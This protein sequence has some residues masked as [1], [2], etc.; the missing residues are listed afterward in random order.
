MRTTDRRDFLKASAAA[1][2]APAILHRRAA[3]AQAPI[4]FSTL[5]CPTWDWTTILDRAAEWGFAAVELRG[6]QGQMDLTRCPEFAPARLAR[7]RR[8][9][10]ERNLLISD[11]GASCRL[12]EKDPKVRA[13]QLD[14]ARRFIELAHDLGAPYVRVFGDKWIAGES[15]EITLERIG[16]GLR[17]LGRFAQSGKVGVIIET[18][19]DFT[20]ADILLKL[21][22]SAALAN[23][24][25][26]WDTHHTFVAG[27]EKPETTWDVLG[28]YVRHTHLKDS[29][30]EGSEIRYVLPG[31]GTVPL[32]DIVQVLRKNGYRG[33]YG[34]EWEKAWHPEIEEPEI[35]FPQFAEAMRSYLGGA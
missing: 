26:L 16:V 27:K 5:G 24:G 7:T 35:A 14:E 4:S 8:E 22:K 15:R 13:E 2:G 30:P 29:R 12:H 11:L 3:A 31:A 6:L 32:K 10:K 21:L 9:L 17:E 18:H 23:V 20:S 33:F 28:G 25:L 19:G 1:L 34:F